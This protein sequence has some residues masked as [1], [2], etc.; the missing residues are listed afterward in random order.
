MHAG[1]TSS[2]TRKEKTALKS[3]SK[4]KTAMTHECQDD[5][6]VITFIASKFNL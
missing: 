6:G 1:S 4:V 5:V 3:L 2:V